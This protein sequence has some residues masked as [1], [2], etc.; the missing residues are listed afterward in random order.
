MVDLK[1]KRILITAGPTWVA[2]DEVRIISNTATGATGILL[3]QYLVKAGAKVTLLL[4]PA[5]CCCLDKRIRLIRFRFFEELRK[6]LAG[7]IKNRRYSAVIHSAAVSD[8]RVR[9]PLRGKIKS[10]LKGWKLNLVPTSKIIDTIKRID[11]AVFL[12]GFKFQP[13]AK[14]EK[15]I[16]QAKTLLR[17]ANLDLVVANTAKN[18]RYAAYIVACSQ[19]EGPFKTKG[20]LV[21]S[22]I[23]KL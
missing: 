16:S 14:K 17:R 5:E 3:A 23:A 22:L 8:Y 4:G 12:V 7:E 6:R 9:H 20:A 2:I 11:P 18:G 13:Q 21:K 15:L 19:T 1:N 10:G